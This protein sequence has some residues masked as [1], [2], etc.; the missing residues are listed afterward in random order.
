MNECLHT[1]KS[2]DKNVHYSILVA[3]RDIAMQRKAQKEE[4]TDCLTSWSHVCTVRVK[5]SEHHEVF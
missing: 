5:S 4:K 2:Q 1:P 3:F